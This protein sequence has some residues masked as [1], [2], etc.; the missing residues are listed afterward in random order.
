MRKILESNVRKAPR[1]EINE[2]PIMNFLRWPQTHP[3]EFTKQVEFK[4]L[5]SGIQFR[6]LMTLIIIYFGSK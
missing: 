3:S 4:S 6:K 1:A 2:C 5:I